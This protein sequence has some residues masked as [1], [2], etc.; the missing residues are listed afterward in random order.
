MARATGPSD[1]QGHSG[2]RGRGTRT[3]EAVS[4]VSAGFTIRAGGRELSRTPLGGGEGTLE[5]MGRADGPERAFRGR[6]WAGSSTGT[7]AG[8]T[9]GTRAL[10]AAASDEA[11]RG[12]Q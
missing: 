8:M 11:G 5:Q 3:E 7:T 6:V 10:K 2:A 9:V 12:H 1:E 4:R